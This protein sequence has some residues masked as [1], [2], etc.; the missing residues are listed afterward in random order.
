MMSV[1]PF[2]M[3]AKPPVPPKPALSKRVSR[4]LSMDPVATSLDQQLSYV[5]NVFAP[6]CNVDR[7]LGKG[8][9]ATIFGG[10]YK[11]RDAA[12]KIIML[13]DR[14]S[15]EGFCNEVR[16]QLR[17]AQLED[18]ELD[19]HIP[20]VYLYSVRRHPRTQRLYGVV[21][22]EKIRM[23]LHDYLNQGGR[24]NE[25]AGHMK[26]VL[27]VL[28]KHDIVHGDL[29]VGNVGITAEG[30]TC[31]LDFDYTVLDL[32]PKLS[33]DEVEYLK[34][35]DVASVWRISLV[36]SPVYA[37]LNKALHEI[38]FPSSTRFASKFGVDKPEPL[39]DVADVDEGIFYHGLDVLRHA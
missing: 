16:A 23:T 7:F 2:T 25:V 36:D 34:D 17:L 37:A 6:E 24:V 8:S 29:H 13:Q 27:A 28:Q 1:K 35:A 38:G 10:S 19:I 3:A 21:V 32:S 31:L 5:H 22:M 11:G 9:Y 18:L 14:P 4:F 33:A 20:S 30:R 12:I 26:R 15:Y 39:L